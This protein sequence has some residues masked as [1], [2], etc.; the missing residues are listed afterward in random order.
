MIITPKINIFMDKSNWSECDKNLEDSVKKI[1]IRSLLV[2]YI[3]GIII[4]GHVVP[5]LKKLILIKN[6]LKQIIVLLKI[7]IIL[8]FYLKIFIQYIYE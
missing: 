4:Y 3:L 2:I 5:L 1:E 8:M 6:Y 7:L